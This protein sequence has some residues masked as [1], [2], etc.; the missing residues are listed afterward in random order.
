MKLGYLEKKIHEAREKSLHELETKK[1]RKRK[2]TANNILVKNTNDYPLVNI[3]N[4]FER[5]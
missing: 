2:K 4:L 5:N 3:T 1:F